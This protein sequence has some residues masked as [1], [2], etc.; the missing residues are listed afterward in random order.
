MKRYFG[1]NMPQGLG[2]QY[3]QRQRCIEVHKLALLLA[4]PHSVLYACLFYWNVFS[5]ARHSS[6]WTQILPLACLTPLLPHSSLLTPR[7]LKAMEFTYYLSF[8]LLLKL[9]KTFLNSRKHTFLHFTCSMRV[10]KWN[11]GCKDSAMTHDNA[12]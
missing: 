7:G 6:L 3:V 2:L 5:K 9:F 8:Q 1:L 12:R 11:T 4:N 10:G